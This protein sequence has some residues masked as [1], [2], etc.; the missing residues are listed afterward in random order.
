MLFWDNT[1][2]NVISLAIAVTFDII[3]GEYPTAIH[4][5]VY[6]GFLGKLF[7]K[8]T[9]N[10]SSDSKRFILGML[11]EIFEISFWVSIVFF[12]QGL[13]SN[14]Y[15]VYILL[16]SYLTKS[17]FAI[18][19]LYTHVERCNVEDEKIL[20]QNVSMIVS[21]DTNNLS[22]QHLYSAALESLAENFNDSVV[23]PIFYF[24]LF[25]LPGA[26]VY[27]II[28]TYDALFGY[29][30]QTYEWFGKFPARLDDVVNYI[31]ARLS[32]VVISLFNFRNAL[33]YIKLYGGLKINGTY[34]MSAFAGVLN[35]GFEKIGT[36]RF[37][38]KLPEK[39]DLERGLMLY[40]KI[41]SV[42]LFI[43]FLCYSVRILL[44]AGGMK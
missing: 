34:P 4:P 29:R 7:D 5:V 3:F 19:S 16:C 18:K 39:T 6:F 9:Q 36:Y 21:R 32:A 20:R 23:A 24:L 26:V 1:I 25:G 17:T 30:N 27:R 35:I 28:N 44:S 41:C 33:K 42:W 38:G 10:N 37:E 15:F 2:D 12:V 31:P 22:K 40:K 13:K 11:S 43:V 8:H 14:Y